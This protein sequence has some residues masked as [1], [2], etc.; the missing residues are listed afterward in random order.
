MTA[1]DCG[2]GSGT[3]S[4]KGAESARR[5]TPAGSWTG[6][7]AAVCRTGCHW[8]AGEGGAGRAAEA[9]GT[10]ATDCAGDATGRSHRHLRPPWS[11]D[12]AGKTELEGGR[13]AGGKA[14][15]GEEE[16]AEEEGRPRGEEWSGS[17]RSCGC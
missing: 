1:T 2:T 3:G 13:R 4:R 17:R 6:E 15:E 5:E 8:A 14:E 16:E 10:H 12:Q 9:G 7:V 11:L